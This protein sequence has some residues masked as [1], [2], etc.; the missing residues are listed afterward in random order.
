[1]YLCRKNGL[2]GYVSRAGVWLVEPKHVSATD[3][4]EGLGAGLDQNGVVHIFDGEGK[5]V[6]KHE[7]VEDIGLGFSGGYLSFKVGGLYGFMDEHAHEIVTPQFKDVGQVVEG[8]VVALTQDAEGI[9]RMDG[10]WVLQPVSGRNIQ[11][12]R[13]GCSVTTAAEGDGYLIIAKDGRIVGKKQ[14]EL[15]FACSEG[16]IPISFYDGEKSFGW[17]D[18][19]GEVVVG[20]KFDWLN[21]EFSS[22]TICFRLDGK[23]GISDRKGQQLVPPSFTYLNP[24]SEG[25]HGA[26]IGGEYKDLT[27]T[28][29]KWGFV[30]PAGNI[31]VE[32]KYDGVRPF[33]NGVALVYEGRRPRKYSLIDKEGKKIIDWS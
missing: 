18:D 30:D 19:Q 9:L 20:P 31:V 28:G 5:Q 33:K 22:E 21:D 27:P 24:L 4:D 25:L 15:L 11:S 6:G 12:F 1:M 13:K 8:L 3:W 10:S 16:L 23:W 14:C 2:F 26:L 7:K 32:A 17:L 29:G